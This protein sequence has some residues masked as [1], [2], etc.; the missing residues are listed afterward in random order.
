MLRGEGAF[1]GVMAGIRAARGEGIPVSIA[2][3]IHGGNLQEFDMLRGFTEKIDAREWGIDILCM[4]G[5]LVENRHL[6]VP[7]EVAAPL[8]DY[9]FGGG[10][11]GSS[12][13]FSCGRHLMTVTPTGK[14]LKC[15]F[16]EDYPLGDAR[17]GLRP[18]WLKLDHIPVAALECRDCPAVEECAG[19][20]RFRA[21]HPLGPDRAMCA[22]YGIDPANMKKQRVVG[23][24]TP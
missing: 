1:D 6:A 17:Q 2:T 18:C 23:R 12:D 4:A 7:C 21:D 3:M 11:H 13:G 22:F 9:S 8:M 24:I 20:C 10:Y 14:A 16:Y 19:G 5:S 15:G